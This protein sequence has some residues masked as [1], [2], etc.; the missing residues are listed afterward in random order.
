MACFR[1]III[2]NNL[3]NFNCSYICIFHY[4]YCVF[5][6]ETENTVQVLE[7]KLARKQ[8]L[9][10]NRK[11]CP[12]SVWKEL[13][14]IRRNVRQISRDSKAVLPEHGSV[15]LPILR[16]VLRR[17]VRAFVCVI[18]PV[19]LTCIWFGECRKYIGWPLAGSEA[20]WLGDLNS[21]VFCALHDGRDENAIRCV[22]I[23]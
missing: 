1:H 23:L 11:Y 22:K 4:W 7:P 3:N 17:P 6:M 5:Y 10:L 2:V 19:P 21:Y 16:A 9:W 13:R 20:G 18:V 12:D 14:K 8:G 15:V